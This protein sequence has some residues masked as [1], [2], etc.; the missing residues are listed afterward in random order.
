MRANHGGDY[1]Q[2]DRGESKHQQ[3]RLDPPWQRINTCNSTLDVLRRCT[4][5]INEH[6]TYLF[7]FLP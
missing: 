7:Y 4:I 2:N 6:I 3:R 1:Q 5:Y